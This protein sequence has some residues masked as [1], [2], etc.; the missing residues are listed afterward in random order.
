MEIEIRLVYRAYTRWEVPVRAIYRWEVPVRATY[1]W[2]VPV[3]VIYRW[4]VP[5]LIRSRE[6]T[7]LTDGRFQYR[8]FA[9]GRFDLGRSRSS[10]GLCRGCKNPRAHLRGG[11]NRPVWLFTGANKAFTPH[12]KCSHLA[13][14][15]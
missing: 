9:D 15:L 2:E 12:I 6:Y 13:V 5:I 3:R 4:E 7:L 1:R 10:G 8:P 14:T 11:V